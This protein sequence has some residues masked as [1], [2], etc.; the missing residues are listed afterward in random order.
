M[1]P[2]A[3]AQYLTNVTRKLSLSP[4]RSFFLCIWDGSEMYQKW[5]FSPQSLRTRKYW[6]HKD[7]VGLGGNISTTWL[8]MLI[9]LPRNL[10]NHSVITSHVHHL[11]FS[12]KLEVWSLT[13]PT[14]SFVRSHCMLLKTLK[15]CSKRVANHSMTCNRWTG[16]R[17]K[18]QRHDTEQPGT[19]RRTKLRADHYPVLL[20]WAQANTLTFLQSFWQSRKA[21]VIG[22]WIFSTHW[23]FVKSETLFR[24]GSLMRFAPLPTN[25][26]KSHVETEP[27]PNNR[28]FCDFCFSELVATTFL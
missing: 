12:S 7:S 18:G 8:F 11:H 16:E 24:N 6:F 22:F 17:V 27:E 14:W 15:K 3:A 26:W 1:I 20:L 28:F 19:I 13:S 23:R 10:S 21:I 9:H 4:V 2:F 25:K 5:C